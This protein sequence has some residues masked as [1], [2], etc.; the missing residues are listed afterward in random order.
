M[1]W[2][3]EISKQPKQASSLM[4]KIPARWGKWCPLLESSFNIVL[5]VID[6]SPRKENYIR[7]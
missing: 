4:V 5:E 6:N 7:M 1:D 3:G 2:I